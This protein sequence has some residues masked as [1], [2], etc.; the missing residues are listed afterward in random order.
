M[1]VFLHLFLTT[2]YPTQVLTMA[3]NCPLKLPQWSWMAKKCGHFWQ[4]NQENYR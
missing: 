3:V 1:S 4:R 2:K